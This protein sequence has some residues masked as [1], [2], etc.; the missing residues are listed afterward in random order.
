MLSL[1]WQRHYRL[2]AISGLSASTYSCG[3]DTGRFLFGGGEAAVVL[4]APF[5]KYLSRVRDRGG[6]AISSSSKSI[7]GAEDNDDMSD[8]DIIEVP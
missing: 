7:D 1:Y 4:H 8:S 2:T 5:L 6:L 3:G